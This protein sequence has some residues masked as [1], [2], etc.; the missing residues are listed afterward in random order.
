MLKSGVSYMSLFLWLWFPLS[1]LFF[2]VIGWNYLE[3]NIYR[4]AFEGGIESGARQASA[5]I[6]NEIIDKSANEECNTVFV[7]YEGRRVDL[8][9]VRCLQVEQSETASAD[10]VAGRG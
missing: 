2:G 1:L 8:I 9:N 10:D 5:E 4:S 3:T 6:Y 7:Q